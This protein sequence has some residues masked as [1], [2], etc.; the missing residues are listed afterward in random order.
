M[1]RLSSHP[2]V[3]G[4]GVR[5]FPTGPAENVAEKRKKIFRMA[6]EV[7]WNRHRMAVTASWPRDLAS[8]PVDIGLEM[9]LLILLPSFRHESRPPPRRFQFMPIVWGH[10]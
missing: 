9:L 10:A 4:D 8:N 2:V 5:L 3:F 7:L 1:V 6:S